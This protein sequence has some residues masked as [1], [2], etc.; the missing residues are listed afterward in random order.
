MKN[1]SNPFGEDGDEEEIF[2]SM[3]GNKGGAGSMEDMLMEMM[4]GG[5]PGGSK[6]TNK[7]KAKK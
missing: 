3:F 6:K 2:S 5:M 7:R 4:M 1:F